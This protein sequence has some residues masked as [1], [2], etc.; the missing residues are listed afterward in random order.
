MAEEVK[1]SNPAPTGLAGFGLTTV[2]LSLVLGGALPEAG[3]GVVLPLAL[4]YGGLVQLIAGV[5]EFR[6]GNTFG[7]AAFMSYGGFWI[8]YA[9]LLI[10]SGNGVINLAKAGPTVGVALLLWGVFTFYMWIA[11]FKLN[12]ALWTVF[13]TLWIAYFLIGVGKITG[14]SVLGTI[15]GWVAFV[16]GW[17][18]LYTSFAI[19]TNATFNRAV[20]PLGPLGD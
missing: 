6:T 3:L 14:I 12:K 9:L 1:L 16:C 10:L 13:F 18:A 2:L 8:W 4:A 19:V 20:I 7:Q 5:T 15:G 11:T 17:S